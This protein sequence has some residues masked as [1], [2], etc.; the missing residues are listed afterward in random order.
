MANEDNFLELKNF[1]RNKNYFGLDSGMFMVFTQVTTPFN[2]SEQLPSHKRPGPNPHEVEIADIFG[3]KR[4][5]RF[6][7]LPSALRDFN[8]NVRR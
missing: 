8:Q 2:P 5:R 4:H 3:P 1:I 6:F 7:F